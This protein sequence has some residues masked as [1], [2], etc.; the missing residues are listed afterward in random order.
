[1]LQGGLVMARS[2]RA[3]TPFKV[4]EVGTSRKAVCDF[5]LVINTVCSKKVKPK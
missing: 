3:I 4:I 5:L 1:M 2:R